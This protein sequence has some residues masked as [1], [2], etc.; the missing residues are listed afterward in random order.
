M[1]RLIGAK[2]KLMSIVDVTYRDLTIKVQCYNMSCN[3]ST[4][5]TVWGL[6]SLVHK[7]A[8]YFGCNWKCCYRN[9]TTAYYD[10]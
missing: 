2:E 3:F 8:N 7:T 5:I 10:L 6:M 9:T 1:V 4:H